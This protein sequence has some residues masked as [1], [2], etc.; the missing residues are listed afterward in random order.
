MLTRLLPRQFDNHYRGAKAALWIFGV[1]TFVNLAIAFG[2]IFAP[3]G[4]AKADGIPLADYGPAAAQAVLGISA[5]LGL[6]DLLMCA[7]GVL[8]L[9]RYRAMVP[10]MYVVIVVDHLGHKG[11][12]LLKPIAR[13]PGTSHG[14]IVSLAL[15]AVT[16]LGLALSITGK[17]Y[18]ARGESP[19]D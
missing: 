5:Y 13:A 9:L 11:I 2:G 14:S 8:S 17:G 12:N 6:S 10:L 3:D 18:A 7:L 1:L 15:F 19:G 16:I 4:G